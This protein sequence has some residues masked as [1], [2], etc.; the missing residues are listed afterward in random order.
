MADVRRIGGYS[1]WFRAA[2]D[3]DLLMR[4]SRFGTLRNVSEP[5][6]RHRIH[7]DP[8]RLSN[9]H[10]RFQ[11]LASVRLAQLMKAD[12]TIPVIAHSDDPARRIRSM[13]KP[14][15]VAYFRWL[16]AFLLIEGALRSSRPAKR[17]F[18]AFLRVTAKAL[19]RAHVSVRTAVVA[20]LR[21]LKR[22][23]LDP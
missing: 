9:R 2:H 1:T 23:F 6:V 15:D 11:A 13:W 17:D 21:L 8:A 16:Y 10:R 14:Q 5:L 22:L 4:L 20:S 3:Q 12:A 7:D 19:L 18:L